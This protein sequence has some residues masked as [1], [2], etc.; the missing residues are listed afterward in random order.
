M[1]VEVC[2]CV[3]RNRFPFN[4]G[5][6]VIMFLQKTSYS[7]MAIVFTDEFGNKMALDSTNMSVRL[8]TMANMLKTYEVVETYTIPI[9]AADQ[10]KWRKWY[11]Q[12][13]GA[14]Y[15]Y[16]QIF[17][18]F[19]KIIRAIKKNPWGKDRKELSCN[20]LVAIMLED[21][22]GEHF[23]DTDDLDL[24]DVDTALM[25]HSKEHYAVSST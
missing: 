10:T 17:G 21:W 25:R 24:N 18:L 23:R 13:L 16:K 1:M 11:S 2:K 14:K 20:E 3:S 9:H 19:L 4:I 15:A 5:S 7:H 8:Q 22:H 12:F 6:L